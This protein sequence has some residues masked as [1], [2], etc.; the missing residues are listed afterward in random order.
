M[1]RSACKHPFIIVLMLLFIPSVVYPAVGDTVLMKGFDLLPNTRQNAVRLVQLALDSCKKLRHPVLVF[2]KGR[3]DFWP[4]YAIEKDYFE[5][6]STDINPKRCAIMV[7][8]FDGL[9]I[10]AGG[11]DFIFHDRM[12]PFTIDHSK[13]IAIR[14]VR[15][16]WDI[17]LTAQAT[18]IDT[19]AA[20]VD[21]RIDP[22]QFPFI[23]EDDKIVFVGE[24]WKSQ[25]WGM[26]EFE[27]SSGLIAP[28][29]GDDGVLGDNWNRYVASVLPSG[30]IRMNFPFKRK[31][32]IGNTLVL[33]HSERD[34]AGIFI[35][36]SSRV[37]LDKITIYHTAGLGVL[38]QYSSDLSFRGLH[39]IPN[40]EKGRVFSGHDDGCHF[41][42]CKGEILVDS[43]SFRGLMDDPI[44]VHGTA[45][46]VV[47]MRSDRELVCRFMHHQ[48][49]GMDWGFQGDT[50]GF[51]DHSTMQTIATGKIAKISFTS[52][53]DFVLSFEQP[54]PSSLKVKDALE[55]LTWTPSIRIAN[56]LFSVNRARGILVSTPGKVLIENNRFESSGS[57]ILIAGDANQ[58]FESGA[59]KDVTIRKNTFTDACLTSMYQ[60]CEAII[61]IEPEIPSLSAARPFHRNIR[62]EENEFHSFDYPVLYA[63]STAGISFINNTITR[64]T[65]FEPFHPRK[66]MLSFVACSNIA[67]TGNRL[68]GDVLG[69]NILLKNTNKK[70]LKSRGLQI[71]TD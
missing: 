51:I 36:G 69:K 43:C 9:D 46:Q 62:V 21:I 25:L 7:H 39:V 8:A 49:V 40:L 52:L 34:H 35:L 19:G 5:S 59:V 50:V 45:V 32:S 24:G 12:Q 30:V 65:R 68:I 3:Y 61:S 67:V 33:R 4:Q 57:A 26:M 17:P 60:F 63:K 64:S 71:V 18:V 41:S 1:I 70:E 55:N 20:F 66:S 23:I 56:S 22:L 53:T 37:S 38:S 15:I 47:A 16:D 58:W 10:D 11:S 44:N 29:T 31:P 13:N 14:N 48:S 54:V 2:E 42:N 28:R 27:K 6:N